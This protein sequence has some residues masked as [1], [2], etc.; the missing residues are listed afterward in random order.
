MSTVRST[1]KSPRV[2]TQP[3]ARKCVVVLTDVEWR[4][5]RVAAAEDGTT[6]QGWLTNVS[7]AALQA[8]RPRA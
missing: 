5:L 7:L 3:R 6:M 1:V 8:R 2:N 4:A